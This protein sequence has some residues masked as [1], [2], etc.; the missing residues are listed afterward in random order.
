TVLECDHIL[1]FN[2]AI[3]FFAISEITCPVRNWQNRIKNIEAVE[4]DISNLAE[5]VKPGNTSK[6]KDLSHSDAIEEISPS[7]AQRFLFLYENTKI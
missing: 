3:R 4:E 2:Y 1:Y 6:P 5:A 7:T